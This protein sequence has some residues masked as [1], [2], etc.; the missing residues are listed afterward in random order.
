MEVA[1]PLYFEAF[2]GWDYIGHLSNNWIINSFRELLHIYIEQALANTQAVN[3]L[4]RY[5]LAMSNAAL[6]LSVMSKIAI[7]A[8]YKVAAIFSLP[9]SVVNYIKVT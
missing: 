7:I 8:S 9:I 2:K 3:I 5:Y 1:C 4:G 6:G